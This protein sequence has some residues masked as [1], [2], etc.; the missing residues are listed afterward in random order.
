MKSIRDIVVANI[1]TIGILVTLACVT[2]IQVERELFFNG[3][4]RTQ[5][6]LKFFKV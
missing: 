4:S 5:Y 2:T 6:K 1:L 3:T